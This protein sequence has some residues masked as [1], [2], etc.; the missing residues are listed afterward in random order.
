[1]GFEGGVVLICQ[2]VVRKEYSKLFACPTVSLRKHSQGQSSSSLEQDLLQFLLPPYQCIKQLRCSSPA[3][4]QRIVPYLHQYTTFS[5][6][7]CTADSA[8]GCIQQ[9]ASSRHA[10]SQ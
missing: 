6:S 2:L 10:P 9:L 8:E 5:T 3:G 7:S 4:S 1:M